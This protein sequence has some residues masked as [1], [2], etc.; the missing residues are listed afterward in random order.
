MIT[1]PPAAFSPT[2]TWEIPLLTARVQVA[3]RPDRPGVQNALLL[4]AQVAAADAQ[5]PRL[6]AQLPATSLAN[7]IPLVWWLLVIELLGLVSF[8]LAALV[9]RGLYDRGWGFSKLLGMLLLAYLTWLPA[10]VR[11]L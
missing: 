9:F 7:A 1:C 11:V 3:A 8:P 5:S 6:A 2:Q 4:P 10:S